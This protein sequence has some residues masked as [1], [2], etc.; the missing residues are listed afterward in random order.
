MFDR[1]APC[2]NAS[3][4]LYNFYPFRTLILMLHTKLVCNE[5][6]THEIDPFFT[7]SICLPDNLRY[8]QHFFIRLK[9][10]RQP[11]HFCV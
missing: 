3:R 6:L 1:L 2:V 9:M 8:S 7:E 10:K 5:C 4:D 11:L